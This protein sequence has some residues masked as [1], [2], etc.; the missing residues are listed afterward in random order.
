MFWDYLG[1]FRLPRIFLD[2]LERFQT[3]KNILKLSET[4]QKQNKMNRNKIETK[5]KQKGNKRET[6]Q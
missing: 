6:K 4:K 2:Y 1:P 3:I 5:R